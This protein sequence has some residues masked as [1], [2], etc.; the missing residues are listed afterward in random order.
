MKKPAVSNRILPAGALG[1]GLFLCALSL[2]LGLSAF[3]QQYTSA[4]L[5]KVS[6]QNKVDVTVSVDSAGTIMLS[7][8]EHNLY[9][10]HPS[11]IPFGNALSAILAGMKDLEA[12]SITVVD[13]RKLG[14]ITTDGSS[15]N[16]GDGIKFG[17]KFNST[18]ENKVLLLMYSTRYSQDLIFTTDQ[19]TQLDDYVKKALK[20]GVEYNDQYAYIQYVTE[21]IDSSAFR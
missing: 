3:A 16:I 1:R 6:T 7:T 8:P 15:N 21:K 10:N 9:I 5:G 14:S 17:L 13:Y 11:A 20:S 18:K 12:K 4:V 2:S 19:L